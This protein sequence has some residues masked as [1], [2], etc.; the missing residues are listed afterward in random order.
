FLSLEG[1]DEDYT[2]TANLAVLSG[3]E[4]LEELV[5]LSRIL[6]SVKDLAKLPNLKRLDLSYST[7]VEYDALEGL[8]RSPVEELSLHHSDLTPRLLEGLKPFKHLRALDLSM[9]RLGD[10]KDLSAFA[11]VEFLDFSHQGLRNS[12]L[13]LSVLEQLPK[14]RELHV[15]NNQ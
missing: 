1:G 5:L 6:P 13:D 2:E 3:F 10:A 9:N 8:E 12:K 7:F 14:L 4:K 11:T 15:G